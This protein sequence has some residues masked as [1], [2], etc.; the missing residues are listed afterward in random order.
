MKAGKLD[1]LVRID[2]PVPD[3]D[4]MIAPRHEWAPLWTCDA[5]I[6]FGNS[7][8]AFSLGREGAA[9][10]AQVFIRI[11]PST[12]NV[13]SACRMVDLTT[14]V[15]YAIDSVSPDDDRTM[16]RLYCVAGENDG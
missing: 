6:S 8:E 2:E 16:L 14:G 12:V 10:G 13:T 11:P 15:I 7:R 3:V 9:I 1:D 4:G 5:Q